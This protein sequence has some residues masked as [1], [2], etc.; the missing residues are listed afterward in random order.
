MAFPVMASASTQIFTFAI[1]VR[2]MAA[3]AAYSVFVAVGV[4]HSL[5]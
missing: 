4:R 2:G 1:P 3:L 5:R